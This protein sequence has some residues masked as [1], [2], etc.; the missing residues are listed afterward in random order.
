MEITT[1]PRPPAPTPWGRWVLLVVL[2][3]PVTVLV[4][5]PIGL[6]LERVVIT[7]SSMDGPRDGGLSRGSIAFERIVPVSDLR[8]G[9]VITYQRPGAADGDAMVTHR[10]VATGP[11]GIVTRGDAVPTADPWTLRPEEPTLRRVEF[12]VPWV[13][14]AYLLHLNPVGWALTV[15]SALVLVALGAQRH[16][17][18][19]PSLRPAEGPAEPVTTPARAREVVRSERREP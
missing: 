19:T 11:E 14:W 5:L 15:G 18:R 13:G 2:I 8:V 9:D 4:L 12:A 1:A 16:R 17:R 6:G 7:G 10:I 3:A